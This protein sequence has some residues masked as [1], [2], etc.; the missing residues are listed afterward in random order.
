VIS[1]TEMTLIASDSGNVH[2]FKQVSGSENMDS[3]IYLHISVAW[4]RLHGA[5]RVSN[6]L[7]SPKWECGS[8]I[9]MDFVTGVDF[10]VSV[11]S[12]LGYAGP[13]G[14]NKRPQY[15]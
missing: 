14:S 12:H 1:V 10:V 5:A 8:V 3:I 9:D 6:W 11:A 7:S 13:G 2:L 15:G 4:E